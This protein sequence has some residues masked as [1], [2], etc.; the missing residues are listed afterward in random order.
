MKYFILIF[1][2]ILFSAMS[3]SAGDQAELKQL[4]RE[5]QMLRRELDRLR[6][7]AT[8]R[9]KDLLLFRQWAAG[10]A[11][12][13]K[14]MKAS[15]RESRLM[16]VLQE[17]LKRS[18]GLVLESMDLERTIRDLLKDFPL[19]PARQ[20]RLELQLDQFE[21][22]VRQVSAISTI[23][24]NAK[25]D[26]KYIREVRILAI[27]RD[28]ETVVVSSGSVHG[29]FPGLLYQGK[30]N[31]DLELRIISV[32]PWVSAAVPVRGNLDLMTP[33]MVFG[34]SRRARQNR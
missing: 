11:D 25:D 22:K 12:N 23:A 1:S 34:A 28:S 33:G 18:N 8:Q 16:S 29:I 2:V 15:E 30:T 4:R 31:R 21:S 5:N 17:F 19:S 3:L 32:R 10:V 20:A 7:E 24:E 13:G 9:D 14:I 6:K 26:N 27:D